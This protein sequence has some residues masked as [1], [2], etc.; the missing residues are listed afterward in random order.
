MVCNQWDKDE[1]F[2]NA[3]QKKHEFIYDNYRQYIIEILKICPQINNSTI[4]N[5]DPVIVD[6]VFYMLPIEELVQIYKLDDIITRN[7]KFDYSYKWIIIIKER[8]EG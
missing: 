6:D 7:K 5:A 3:S 1:E 2:F 8:N 4:L